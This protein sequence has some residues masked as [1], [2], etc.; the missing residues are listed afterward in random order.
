MMLRDRYLEV[1]YEDLC[2][3]FERTAGRLLAFIGAQD[4]S[5]AIA[6]VRSRV[7]TDRVGKHRDEPRRKQRKVVALI[8][9]LLL[10]LGYLE[11][12]P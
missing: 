4:P 9:P 10:E 7:R 6:R 12:D 3:D 5:W 1:R 11:N 8:K 2:R